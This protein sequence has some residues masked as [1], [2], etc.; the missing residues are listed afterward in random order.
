MSRHRRCRHLELL[1]TYEVIGQPIV[2]STRL[3]YRPWIDQAI[4]PYGATR[5]P[6]GTIVGLWDALQ[7][8]RLQA[9]LS[10]VAPDAAVEL[11]A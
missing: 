6:T 1:E 10:P 2:T 3:A 11:T 5:L 9:A 4:A 7:Q 8:A